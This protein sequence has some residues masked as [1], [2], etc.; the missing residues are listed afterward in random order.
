MRRCVIFSKGSFGLSKYQNGFILFSFIFENQVLK[1]ITEVAEF[2]LV[3]GT[4][5]DLEEAHI[6]VHEQCFSLSGL[7]L[8]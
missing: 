8:S 4:W 7:V 2:F 6:Y 5:R 3:E 1:S